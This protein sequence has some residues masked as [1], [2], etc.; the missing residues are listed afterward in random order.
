MMDELAALPPLA[1]V[2]ADRSPE[3]MTVEQF[4]LEERLTVGV[5]NQ[6]LQEAVLD[7]AALR[8][9]AEWR[10]LLAATAKARF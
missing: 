3:E 6:L 1:E 7:R 9:L 4:A 8:T 5:V 10:S 2:V